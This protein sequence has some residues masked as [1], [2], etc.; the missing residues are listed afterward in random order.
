MLSD[1]RRIIL[2]DCGSKLGM[3]L[4]IQTLILE[5]FS[6]ICPTLFYCHF[7]LSGKWVKMPWKVKLLPT[8]G[9]CKWLKI[10]HLV[11]VYVGGLDEA[12]LLLLRTVWFYDLMGG[13]RGDEARSG[14]EDSV[15]RTAGQKAQIFFSVSFLLNF[16]FCWSWKVSWVDPRALWDVTCF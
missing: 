1:L 15:V 7:L 14:S 11:C 10:L 16:P 6:L 8:Q 12:C 4:N 2:P 5:D 13:G 3:G 9:Y